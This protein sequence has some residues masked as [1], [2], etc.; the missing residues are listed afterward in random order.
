M[1]TVRDGIIAN[2]V[3]SLKVVLIDNGY[4]TDIGSNVKRADHIT[5]KD[6][7]P[8]VRVIPGSETVQNMF[9]RVTLEMD[10]RLEAVARTFG[11]NS[12]VIAEKL[13]GDMIKRMVDPDLPKAHGGL[14]ENIRYNGGGVDEYPEPGQ[15]LVGAYTEFIIKYKYVVGN[16]YE[17]SHIIGV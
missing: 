11:E 3:D 17:Q 6:L 2:V 12:S 8:S 5:D 13:I 15:I 10:M 14:A 16:P 4:Q 7:L 9:K 1:N